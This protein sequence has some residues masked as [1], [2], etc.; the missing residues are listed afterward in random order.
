M[1][2]IPLWFTSEVLPVLDDVRRV[3]GEL[4]YY[5][6]C[7]VPRHADRRRSF[8][9]RPGDKM[10]IVYYC[11]AGCSEEEIRAALAALGVPEEYLGLL[12]TPEYE[13][14]RQARNSG[15]EWR[16]VE[17]LRNEM[18][19][20]KNSIKG[21]MVAD[22]SL[23]MLK[24]RILAVLDEVDVPSSRKNY[25]DFAIQAGVSSAAAYKA[26]LVDP[27][28]QTRTRCVSGDHVVLT[29]PDDDSQPEQVSASDGILET[30]KTLSK[31]E[32]GD[33]R[34]ENSRIEKTGTEAAIA[35]LRAAGL[36]AA[37]SNPAA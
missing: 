4:Q 8:A 19:D 34:N 22:L 18:L 21:L 1:A 24:V 23:A 12:G 20:L 26:W 37:P 33:S 2:S 36:T 3:P 27:L 9:I 7:P 17:R 14:R 35:A 25:V 31:R 30:R 32:D 10:A 15:E 16:Q 29:H 5:A 13:I 11:Q 6:R 28:C